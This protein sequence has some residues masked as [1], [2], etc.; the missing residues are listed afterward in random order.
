MKKLELELVDVFLQVVE[1]HYTLQPAS[2]QF[3]KGKKL[4]IVN[5]FRIE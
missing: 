5:C 2:H 1:D 3:V 4:T